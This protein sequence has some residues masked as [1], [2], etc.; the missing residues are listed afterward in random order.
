MDSHYLHPYFGLVLVKQYIGWNSV[1]I[2]NSNMLR[3][4]IPLCR[5]SRLNSRSARRRH[6]VKEFTHAS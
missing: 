2:D 5:L 1:L 3:L 4:V 6:N